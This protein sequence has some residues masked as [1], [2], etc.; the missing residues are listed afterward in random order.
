MY[1]GVW[2]TSSASDYSALN[3]YRPLKKGNYFR[4]TG[5][6]CTIDGV[7]YRAGDIIAFNR[8]IATSTTITTAAIDHYDHTDNEGMVLLDDTQTLTN[9][10][11]NADNN[12]ISNL[13][14]DNFK[15]GVVNTSI[16]ANPSN[17]YLLTEKAV[18]DG[19][20]LK[21]P[22]ASPAFTGTPTAPTP[23]TTD[24][25]TKIATT[26]YVKNVVNEATAGLLKKAAY[27]NT[28]IAPVDGVCTWTITHTL[29][30]TDIICRVTEVSSGREVIMDKIATSSTVFTIKFNAAASV[31]AN[32]Y[33][34]V[35]IGV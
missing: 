34:A 22:L 19:L 9:K 32:T 12:T 28:L 20:T 13:E 14:I 2:N 17:T 3:V 6:G 7:A 26:Q 30:T 4:V 25:T 5:S 11:I 1:K 18:A 23:A 16:S 8:D 27:N 35:L 15:F 21:A 10:T 24:N 33:R 29:G 31:A